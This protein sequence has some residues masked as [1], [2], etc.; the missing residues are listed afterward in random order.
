MALPA[1]YSF[2]GGLRSHLCR[3]DILSSYYDKLGVHKGAS[4][5]DIKKAFRKKAMEL[6]PDRNPGD[7]KA[8]AEFKE[9][10]EAYAV[11]SDAKKRKQYDMFGDQAFHQQ[12]SQEDIFRGTDFSRVFEEFGMGGSSFFSNIFGGA[13]GFGGGHAGF[14]GPRKGQNV[15]YP[16]T[17]GFMDAYEGTERRVSFSLSDGTSRDIKVKIPKGIEAGQK[18]RVSGKGAPSPDGGPDGD[19]YIIIEVAPHPAFTRKGSDLETAIK[20]NVV[21]AILGTSFEIKTP[22]GSKKVK[23]PAGVQPGTKIRLKEQGFPIHGSNSSFGDLYG[24]VEVSIP[25][26]LTENQKQLVESLKDSGL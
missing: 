7:K 16:V 20:L 24:I 8:E 17:I 2:L 11:L 25:K 6:H 4:D 9:V 23:I 22:S 26:D 18:L 21:D 5:A 14:G 19:L 15:E 10:N 13:Q 3:G 1:P 12:Y